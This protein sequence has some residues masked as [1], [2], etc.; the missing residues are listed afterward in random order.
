[1][2]EL[3][4]NDGQRDALQEV[5]NIGASHAATALSRMVNKNIKIGIPKVE[6]VPLEQIINCVKDQE[7]VV[8]IYLRISNEIPTYI[9]LLISKD[10]AF[11]LARM[12]LGE[13]SETVGS[14]TDMDKSALCEVGNVMMCAF[15]DSITE[16]IGI[17]MIPGP[18]AL[19]YDMP[20][21]IMDYLII[22]MGAVAD[23]VVTFSCN[24]KE[25]GKESFDINLF[26]VPEPKSISIILQKL[27]MN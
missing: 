22:Q 6:V 20:C 14:L 2:Q 11:S 8:G 18:P 5:A 3:T 26:L 21:A 19:A 16:L 25:E 9:L 1:M 12:L 17:S 13:H 4:I 23:K 15:F 10:S 27:G 24:V 7:V